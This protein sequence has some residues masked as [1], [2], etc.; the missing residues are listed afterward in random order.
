MGERN[1]AQLLV[2]LQELEEM[3]REA[4]DPDRKSVV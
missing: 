3:I 4:E 2:A 1:Q